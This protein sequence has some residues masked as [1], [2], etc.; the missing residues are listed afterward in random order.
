ML[1]RIGTQQRAR[2][3]YHSE[4][5]LLLHDGLSYAQQSSA[6]SVTRHQ[7]EMRCLI[8]LCN[9]EFATFN[10]AEELLSL[11]AYERLGP[12]LL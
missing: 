4:E 2:L 1:P 12:S 8:R 7:S 6:A 5:E 9:S 11:P 10:R 3:C